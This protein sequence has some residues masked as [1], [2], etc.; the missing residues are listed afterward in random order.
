MG[1]SCQPSRMRRFFIAIDLDERTRAQVAS[2]VATLRSQFREVGRV[3]WVQPARLHLTLRFLGDVGNGLVQRL[4]SAMNEP[5]PLA[6]FGIAL[7][8]LGTFPASGIPRVLWLGL[9]EGGEQVITVRRI[10]DERLR[11]IGIP[12]EREAFSPH[13]TLARFRD[14]GKRGRTP[15]SRTSLGEKGTIPFLPT[16]FGRC[17]IDRVTVYESRLS[18]AG[19]SYTT[20]AQGL[21]EP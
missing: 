2:Q 21:L 1:R 3:S 20:V 17:Q 6:P 14:R 11:G 5:F 19:P 9:V 7:G 10:V 15:F 8:E 18:S 16:P 12:L 13:L 4:V